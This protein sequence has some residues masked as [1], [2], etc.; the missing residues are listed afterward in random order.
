M[1][2]SP[3]EGWATGRPNRRK[4]NP[5]SLLVVELSWTETAIEWVPALRPERV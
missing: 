5:M 3:V 4:S 2:S 1:R